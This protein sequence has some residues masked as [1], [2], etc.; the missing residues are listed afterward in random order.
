MNASLSGHWINHLVCTRAVE[1]KKI[2]RKPRIWSSHDDT[3]AVV[4]ALI[5]HSHTISRYV[6]VVLHSYHSFCVAQYRLD[7]R[8]CILWYPSHSYIAEYLL[9]LAT[10]DVYGR[11]Q[12]AA[13]VTRNFK[14]KTLLVKAAKDNEII[15]KSEWAS[16]YALAE[17]SIARTV[18]GRTTEGFSRSR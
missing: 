10:H 7:S 2:M 17:S 14:W 13:L 9:Q 5:S 3:N 15:R 6:D 8:K 1:L 4:Y 12:R 18:V 11:S 16:N